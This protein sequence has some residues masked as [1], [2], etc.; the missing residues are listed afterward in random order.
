MYGK[1]GANVTAVTVLIVTQEYIIP[2]V[3]ED[4]QP[5]HFDFYKP[6]NI[7]QYAFCYSFYC[8]YWGKF[9]MANSLRHLLRK[10][11]IS[12]HGNN[13]NRR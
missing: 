12:A 11:K 2:P 6:V 9:L 3:I 7:S 13:L 8:T 1:Y 4:L 10:K 5:C